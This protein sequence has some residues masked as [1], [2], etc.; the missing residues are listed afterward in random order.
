MRIF[1]NTDYNFIKNIKIFLNSREKNYGKID[2]EVKKIVNEVIRKGDKAL[3]NF[4]LKFDGVELNS[5][6]LKIPRKIRNFYRNQVDNKILKSF[7]IS[8]KN[9]TNFHKKQ[10]PKN[11][12][13]SLLEK[14]MLG[15]YQF[16]Y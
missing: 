3:I 12:Q 11:Y 7:K 16:F 13:M 8:V 1:K 2:L 4:S 9:V 15:L 5:S 6:N 14:M 10:F